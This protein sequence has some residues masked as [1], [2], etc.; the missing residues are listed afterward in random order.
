MIAKPMEP[1]YN[2]SESFPETSI[3]WRI[4]APLVVG[5]WALVFV[6]QLIVALF[7]EYMEEAKKNTSSVA[8]HGISSPNTT[9]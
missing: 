1:A 8:T 6:A 7:L 9:T 3:A 5:L 4:V 2:N